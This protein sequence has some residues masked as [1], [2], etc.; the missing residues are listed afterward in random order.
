MKSGHIEEL[1]MEEDVSKEVEEMTKATMSLLPSAVL[2]K[3]WWQTESRCV[4][5]GKGQCLF[6]LQARKDRGSWK[7]Q[8]VAFKILSWAKRKILNICAKRT[9]C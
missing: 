8:T 9:N 3:L 7:L 4:R 1:R 6:C 5:P 2:E